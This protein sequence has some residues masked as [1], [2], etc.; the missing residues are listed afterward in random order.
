LWIANYGISQPGIPKPWGAN[1][2]AFWQF[3]NSDTAKTYGAESKS[4]DLNFFNGDGPAFTQ[5]FNLPAPELPH[6]YPP[7]VPLVN[8]Y[9][10]TPT[11]LNIRAGAGTSFTVVGL[12]KN[13]D[14]VEGLG[15]NADGSWT[16]I[17][18]A[19]GLTGW[20]LSQYLFKLVDTPAP[21]PTGVKY[22]VT[23][24]S[25]NMRTGP[26]TTFAAIGVLK[27]GTIVD[28]L[29][30]NADGSWTQIRRA[31]GFTGWCASRYLIVQKS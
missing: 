2:W 29:G 14:V 15:V 21:I 8:R 7:G 1:E 6:D 23:A 22:R 25:L 27:I 19:D 24:T 16:Q 28:G 5:R 4:I 10:V 9:R 18:R 11:A 26:D 31:D 20:C 3:S 30:I 17:R 13:G 12:L